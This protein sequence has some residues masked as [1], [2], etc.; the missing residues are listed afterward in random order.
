MNDTVFQDVVVILL[1]VA[2]TFFTTV[3][4]F[5]QARMPDLFLRMSASTKA[6]TLGVGCLLAAAALHFLGEP[7]IVA[8]AIATI[9]FLFIT[10]PVAAHL[11]GR[12]GYIYGAKL[13]KETVADEMKTLYKGKRKANIR[14]QDARGEEVQT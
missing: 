2:G 5:G 10:A 4:G 7:L 11:I 13:A 1:L 6:A 8:Q 3:A 12:A 14:V 9:V